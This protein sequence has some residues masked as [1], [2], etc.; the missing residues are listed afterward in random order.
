M[1]LYSMT[2]FFRFLPGEQQQAFFGGLSE[3]ARFFSPNG[4]KSP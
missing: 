3:K 2:G 1:L 4:V